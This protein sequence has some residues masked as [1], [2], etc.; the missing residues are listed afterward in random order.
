MKIKYSHA[1][2]ITATPPRGDGLAAHAAAAYAFTLNTPERVN[3]WHDGPQFA[4]AI[5]EC[6]GMDCPQTA[7]IVRHLEN[8]NQ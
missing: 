2:G 3:V 4:Q 8:L 6:C 1:A 5:R 7:E